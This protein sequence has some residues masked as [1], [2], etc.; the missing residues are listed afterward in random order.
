MH[1]QIRTLLGSISNKYLLF[2]LRKGGDLIGKGKYVFVYEILHECDEPILELILFAMSLYK[3]KMQ[4][5]IHPL[6]L[7]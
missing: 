1:H 7:K 6:N 4:V 5:P 3:C 2:N